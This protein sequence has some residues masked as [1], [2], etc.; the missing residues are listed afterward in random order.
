[1]VYSL[2]TRREDEES[3]RLDY[4]S[5]SFIVAIA[6][7]NSTRLFRL[8]LS[9]AMVYSERSSRSSGESVP[10]GLPLAMGYGGY[11]VCLADPVCSDWTTIRRGLS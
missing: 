5:P 9:L 4:L 8:G 3:F 10:A 1:M 2:D 7:V 6:E 11:L